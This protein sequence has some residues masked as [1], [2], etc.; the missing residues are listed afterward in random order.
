MREVVGHYFGMFG[1]SQDG[2]R[3]LKLKVTSVG[4]QKNC[5]LVLLKKIAF[6]PEI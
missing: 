2:G 1:E 4:V 5:W 3:Y 6:L